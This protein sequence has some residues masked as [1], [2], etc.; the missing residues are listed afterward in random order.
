MTGTMSCRSCVLSS[1][2]LTRRDVL[3]E[4]RYECAHLLRPMSSRRVYGVHGAARQSPLRQKADQPPGHHISTNDEVRQNGC[5]PGQGHRPSCKRGVG[6][7]GRLKLNDLLE[8]REFFQQLPFLLVGSVDASGQPW[9]SVVAGTPGFATSP[10]PQHLRVG[11]LPHAG[12]PLTWVQAARSPGQ[13][14][15]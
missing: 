8:H 13:S 15:R 5:A 7:D 1:N 9:A 10:D 6:C 14:A 2:R 12:D 4:R 3:S 11:V